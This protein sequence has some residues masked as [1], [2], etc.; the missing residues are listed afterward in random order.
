MSTVC[1]RCL[2]ALKQANQ[3]SSSSKSVHFSI[4]YTQII[5]N[6]ASVLLYRKIMPDL[7]C[8]ANR[9]FCAVKPIPPKPKWRKLKILAL[10]LGLTSVGGAVYYTSLS[11][12]Q[13]RKLIVFSGGVRRFFRSLIIGT[14]ISADYKWTLYN[15]AEGS[16]QYEQLLRT[17]HQRAA[18][19][20]L[21][22]CLK[23][24]GLYIKLGQ[25]L[26]SMNHILPKEYLNTLVVL[27]DKALTRKPHEVEQ[28]FMEDFGKKP[29]E[30]FAEFEPEPI[31]A[32][33]LAQ[34]HKATTFDGR[35]VAVKVQYIDLRDRFSG[36]ILTCEILLKLIGWVHPKFSFSWVLQDLKETLRQELDFENEG[37]NAERCQ[38][39]LSHL[40]FIYVPKV[41]WN[42]TTKRVLTAEY[43]DGVKINNLEGIK[44][45]GLSL[46]DVDQKLVK[47]FSDQIF[48]SGFVHA[49]PHPGNVFV[50]KGSD[51]KAQLVLLDHGLYD[52]IKGDH[53]RAL[54]QLYKA[55]IMND[56]EAM[57]SYSQ[58][59]GVED[60]LIFSMMIMQRPVRMKTRRLFDI[61]PP[62]REEWTMMSKE[63]KAVWKEKFQ[64]IHDR[65]LTIMKTMPTSLFWIFR[66]LNTIR[67][68]IRDHGNT[69]DRYGIMARSA[70]KGSHLD[71]PSTTTIAGVFRAWWTRCVYDCRVWR[72]NF[73]HSLMMMV[74]SYYLKFLYLMGR[75][76]PMEEI[77]TF[78]KTEE[79]R[80][81]HL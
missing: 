51:G 13:Q 68:I 77:K 10:A 73:K 60:S 50:R 9:F 18:D 29:E 30:L 62:T 64:E 52:T 57:D 7:N 22:G 79:K 33:S 53:R 34:V 43:I 28:L 76:L 75:S 59:L 49:D 14:L 11:S 65:V 71:D 55:I 66:N 17:C 44:A 1:N 80:F 38:R 35:K 3:L 20:L 81:D 39:D 24:G 6:K 48:L 46:Q 15:V 16:E 37:R 41:Y 69:V 47:S 27:Q 25:G 23:N 8:S 56:E 31:A 70:I 54:C 32:A 21:V 63:E 45:Y 72:E 58:K 74:A 61:K 67:A 12:I 78:M 19:R 2:G 42:M 5:R 40:K 4:N 26:V 36:D